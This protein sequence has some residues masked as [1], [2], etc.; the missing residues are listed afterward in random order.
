[1][2]RVLLVDDQHLV[3]AGLRMLCESAPD[4]EIVGEAVDGE[5]AVR[6]VEKLTP[7]VVL[8]DLRIPRLDGTEATGRILR[9][10]P[11]TRVVVLTAFDDDDHLYPAWAAG[12]C[13]F[14]AK[15]AE[16]AELL[17]AIRRAADGESPF[18]A[19]LLD[20]LVH[21][22]ISAH[23]PQRQPVPALPAEITE[24]ERD[25]LELLGDGPSNAEIAQRLNLGV[26]T[27][28]THIAGL[29]TKTGR[30]NRVQLAILAVQHGLS[31]PS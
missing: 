3:R 10:H 22:A 23:T 20:R 28:K 4:L 1:M 5:Q 30:T 24:R 13:G 2:I 12:A 17:T 29:M 14:L 6:Q 16:P 19:R 27:V 15:N 31:V 26:T 11:A 21:Q 8:M 9:G 25:V 18:S 7:D